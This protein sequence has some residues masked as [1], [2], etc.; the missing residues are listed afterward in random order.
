MWETYH[1]AKKAAISPSEYLG[2]NR[3]EDPWVAYCL[4]RAV[5]T[6][7]TAIVAELDAVEGR[8][9]QEIETKRNRIINRYF[10]SSSGARHQDPA[11][12]QR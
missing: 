11:N 2:I 1:L 3:L 10:P 8:N 12:R 4:D 7:G 5:T 6:F 9:K